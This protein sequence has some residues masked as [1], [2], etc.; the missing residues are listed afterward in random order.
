MGHQTKIDGTWP[1]GVVPYEIDAT[2]LNRNPTIVD[3]VLQ[4]IS[5]ALSEWNQ[6]TTLHFVPRTFESDCVR[7]VDHP[8]GSCQSPVG[9]LADGAQDVSCD[10]DG[11]KEED[12][13]WIA[14]NIMHELGH[15]VGLYHEHQR[16]D[17]DNYVI[18]RDVSDDTNCGKKSTKD[19]TAIGAYD[20]D[21]IMHYASS[22]CS[23]ITAVRSLPA[24]GW[25]GEP[26]NMGNRDKL[27]SGDVNTIR[28]LYPPYSVSLKARLATFHTL[29]PR[30]GYLTDGGM[31]RWVPAGGSLRSWLTY[32]TP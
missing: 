6:R 14:G 25:R 1:N 7:F 31:R 28:T 4:T 18:V 24:T 19:A 23:S 15:A 26:G 17:R 20:F 13:K 3:S 16:P 22:S 12:T 9:Y 29:A 27:S 8:E 10:L 5:E 11:N 21:S 2:L 30:A 32:W